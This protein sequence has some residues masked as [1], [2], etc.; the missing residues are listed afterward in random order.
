MSQPIII[1]TNCG[2]N[3]PLKSLAYQCPKCGGLLDYSIFSNWSADKVDPTQPGIWRWRH[4]F[5][6]PPEVDPVSLGEGNTPLVPANVFGR[7]VYFKCE[8]QN[9]SGSFKDRGSAVI[10]AWLRWQGV[11]EAVEDSSGNAGASFASY[12]GR[13]SIKVQIYIPASASG[14][15]RRQIEATGAVVI[16]IQGS[17]SAVSDAAQHEAGGKI[18]Y[19]SHAWLPYNLPGYATAAYEIVEQLGG[20]FPGAIIVPSGQGGLLLGMW[21]GFEGCA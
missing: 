8:F 3:P 10:T 20:Q 9:P 15:K 11:K 14:P 2:R 7:K 21:R 19:A 18:A 16:P 1:C 5:G 17:R 12:A 13:A 4:A 6:L